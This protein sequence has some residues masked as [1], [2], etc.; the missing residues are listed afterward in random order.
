[1][2]GVKESWV[3]KIVNLKA[4]TPLEINFR[5]EINTLVVK[6]PSAADVIRMDLRPDVSD[7]NYE[8]TAPVEGFGIIVRP[9][10]FRK[11]WLFA[12]ADISNIRVYEVV[13]KEPVIL[14]PQMGQAPVAD[15]NVTGTV[16]LKAGELNLD[17]EKDLQVDVKTLPSLPA[18]TNNIGQVDVKTFPGVVSDYGS[19][20]AAGL[21]V[22]V[23]LGD[24][25]K[26]RFVE[27]WVKSSAAADFLVEVSR[28]NTNWRL[29]DT[30]SLS[31]AGESMAQYETGYRYFQV[32]TTAAND[33]E[34]EISAK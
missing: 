11:A 31:A 3:E 13:T 21:T 17:A 34:I 22:S 20:T 32:R 8:A 24:N 23:D 26:N 10:L 33:N 15:V 29:R 18:G 12:T 1:M 28:D 16:G 19:S 7:T 5:N 4:N 6:N 30:V 9:Y 2:R 27:V 25:T 14:L